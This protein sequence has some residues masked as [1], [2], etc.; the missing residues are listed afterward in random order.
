MFQFMDGNEAVVLGALRAGCD[1]FA[2]YPI[3]PATSILLR[4]VQELPPRGGTV[5]QGEDEMASMGFCIGASMAGRRAL[6]ATSGPGLSLYSENLGMALMMEVPLV[7]V[8]VQRQGPATGSAT[9]VAQGDVQFSRWVTSGGMPMVVLAPST[10]EECYELTMRAFDIAERLRMPVIVLSDKELAMTRTRVDLAELRPVD[11]SSRALHS[12]PGPFKA[13][14]VSGPSEIPPFARFGGEL[15]VR[16]CTSSHDESGYIT[17]DTGAIAR[18]IEH[19]Q[20]KVGSRKKELAYVSKDIQEGARVLV[21]SYG[22]TARSSIQAMR[23]LRKAGVKASLLNV[24]S[25]WPVPEDVIREAA[26]GT[27]LVVVPE[28]NMGQYKQEI[29]RV[30]CSKRVVGV[31]RMDTRLISP[32]EITEAVHALG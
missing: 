13:Y 11:V 3:T 26:E 12:G 19:F 16:A 18:N 32:Q 21:I 10:V 14:G 30:L 4:M 27:E 22:I 2:G 15:V 17:R 7:V 5:I 25:L 28:L 20:A 31:N 9:N 1:F 6:T 24:H 8:V 29:E 23:L